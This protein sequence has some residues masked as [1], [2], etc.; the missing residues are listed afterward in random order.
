MTLKMGSESL[1]DFNLTYDELV[2]KFDMASPHRMTENDKHDAYY[3]IIFQV[4]SS[5]REVNL[6]GRMLD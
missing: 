3:R 5:V 4:I 1:H 2:R 6:I